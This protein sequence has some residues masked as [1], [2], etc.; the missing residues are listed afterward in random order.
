MCRPRR[1]TGWRQK[2]RFLPSRY[3]VQSGLT[4]T[5]SPHRS[6]TNP[7]R[8]P[9]WRFRYQV[10]PIQEEVTTDIATLRGAFDRILHVQHDASAVE[11]KSLMTE[12]RN[13]DTD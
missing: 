13:H 10:T 9:F 6:E 7:A 3:P 11:I 8:I 1:S 5:I 12:V 2:A 4:L